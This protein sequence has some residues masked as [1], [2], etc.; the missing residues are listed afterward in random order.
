MIVTMNKQVLVTSGNL[1][2]LVSSDLLI[3]FWAYQSNIQE[4]DKIFTE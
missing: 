2:F 3:N 1:Y 4:L